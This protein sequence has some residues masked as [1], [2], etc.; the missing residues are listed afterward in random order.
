MVFY[1]AG[2]YMLARAYQAGSVLAGVVISDFTARIG[3]IFL[4]A[5]VLSEPLTGQGS[6]GL[7]RLAGFAAV[8][9]GSVLLG[10]FG[11]AGRAEKRARAEGP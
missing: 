2:F 11:D 4:G 6:A 9:A 1:L 5:M 7:L 10:R 8:L 3:A